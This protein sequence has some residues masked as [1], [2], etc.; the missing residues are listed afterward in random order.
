MSKR[1]PDAQLAKVMFSTTK[2]NTFE[3]RTES[4]GP[5]ATDQRQDPSSQFH[6]SF[7]KNLSNRQ[8]FL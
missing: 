8:N 7:L 3:S 5:Q 4:I 6:D 1:Y 2:V